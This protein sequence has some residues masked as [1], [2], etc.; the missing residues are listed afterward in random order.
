[1]QADVAV[2]GAGIVG[3]SIALHLQ[4]AGK[5]VALIDRRG[6]GEE[7][8]FGNAGLIQ[9]E[10]VEPYGFPLGLWNLFKYAMN[11]RP[12]AHYHWSALPHLARWLAAY[13]WNSRDARHDEITKL[14]APLIEK[15]VDEHMVLARETGALDLLRQN[16]WIKL[17]RTQA[18]LDKVV[19]DAEQWRRDYGVAFN[20]LDAKGVSAL[21][22]HLTG[23]FIGGLHW[24]QPVT[25]IDPHALT[26]AYLSHFERLG[27][28]FIMGDA[29]S[30]RRVGAAWQV[31]TGEGALSAAHAVVALGPWSDTVTKVLGYRFPLA[32]KRG[33]HMH[34]GTQ[35]NAT[36]TRPIL[37][38]ERGFL[39][40][41]MS[42]GIRLTTGAEFALRDA[43]KTPTQL[44]QV[45]PDARG[46]FPLAERRDAEP[47]LGARPC[48]PDMMPVIGK[49]PRHDNL[50]LAF[51]HGH[52]GLTLGAVTGRLI[53]E[54]ICGQAPFVD[55]YPY[56]AERFRM[57]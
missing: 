34:Y 33:Y 38:A 56:R 50:W 22:P 35:G 52:H 27:G 40:A 10:G 31:S 32:V 21:E 7:T 24:T 15:S 47:W 41:P 28:R 18:A 23:A 49:A 46:L 11:N 16:G 43:A 17:F 1:M 53:A 45:E 8:S 48:M 42:K 36:L 55:P 12:D 54:M 26:Q 13:A 5:S 57:A 19:N 2:L 6:A 9:R 25:V 39:L 29:A 14:Y 51:G 3:V 30:L 4:K 44:A 20:L 37:D